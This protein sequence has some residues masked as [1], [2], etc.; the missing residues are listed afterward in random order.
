MEKQIEISQCYHS[1]P[2]F[3]TTN[4]EMY[5]NHP[6]FEDK[7]VYENCIITQD[8]SKNGKVPE[9]CPLRKEQLT[10]NYKLKNYEIKISRR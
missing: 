10:I 7:P 2:F 9:E 8:N 6:F 4:Q 3:K 1:C 5:C